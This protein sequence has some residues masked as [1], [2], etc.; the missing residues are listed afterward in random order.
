MHRS[1]RTSGPRQWPAATRGFVFVAID[2]DLIGDG[3]VFRTRVREII[4]A[5]LSLRPMAGTD[6]AA[7]PGTLEWRR[8]REWRETGLPIPDDHRALLEAIAVELGIDPPPWAGV[9]I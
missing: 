1:P 3:V 2:P 4:D 8:E 9:G 7:L 5:S 6:A